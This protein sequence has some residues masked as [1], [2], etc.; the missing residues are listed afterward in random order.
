PPGLQ[1]STYVKCCPEGFIGSEQPCKEP[2]I[3]SQQIATPSS[4]SNE[5]ITGISIAPNPL[6]SLTQPS[7]DCNPC[8][9]HNVVNVNVPTPIVNLNVNH[10]PLTLSCARSQPSVVSV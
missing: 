4:A 1:I 8:S 6:L 9:P 3:K 5:L 2:T 10:T 7:N